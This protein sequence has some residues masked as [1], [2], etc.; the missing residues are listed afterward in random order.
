MPDFPL[1]FDSAEQY[2]AWLKCALLAN[3]VTSICADCTDAY[4]TA[5]EAAGRCHQDEAAQRFTARRK[6]L[7]VAAQ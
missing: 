4:R 5:M 7:A 1:C 6:P 2:K 3:E